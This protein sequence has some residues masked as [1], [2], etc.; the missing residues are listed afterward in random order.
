MKNLFLLVLAFSFSAIFGQQKLEGTY[1]QSGDFYQG[2]TFSKDGTFEYYA[3]ADTGPEEFGKG[4]YSIKGDSIT[5]NY[6]LTALPPRP[7]HIS[8]RIKTYTDSLILK[9]KVFDKDKKPCNKFCVV[10]AE[11]E[12]ANTVYGSSLT[13]KNGEVIFKIPKTRKNYRYGTIKVFHDLSE[14]ALAGESY[15]FTFE[16]HFSNETEVFLTGIEDDERYIP[17]K[18][19]ITTRKIKKLNKDELVLEGGKF[20]LKLRKEKTK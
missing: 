14:E 18:Y 3:G 10:T 8:Q 5:F 7:Y 12:N 9:I 6:D 13:D 19:R 2:Y 17:I 16:P 4:H 1:G 15:E 20:D 11:G